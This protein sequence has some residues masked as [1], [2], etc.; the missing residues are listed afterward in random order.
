MARP[1]HQRKPTFFWQAALILLPVI[2]LAVMGWFSLRQDKILA[3]HDA[4][5]RAQVIA[6]D[7]LPKIWSEIISVPSRNFRESDQSLFEVD[8]VGNL[9]FPPPRP[10]IPTPKPFDLAE[11]NSEQARLWEIYCQAGART[12]NLETLSKS[13]K[14]FISSDPPENFAAAAQFDFGLRLE[15][16]KKFE[17]AVEAL[18]KVAN[19]YAD[20]LGETGLPLQPLAQLKLIELTARAPIAMAATNFISL[21][22]F[23]SNIV[24]HPTLLTPELWK[25][26]HQMEQQHLIAASPESTHWESIWGNHEAR[27]E[28]FSSFQGSLHSNPISLASHLLWFDWA[29]WAGWRQSGGES[30]AFYRP[31]HC[32]AIRLQ[33][34]VGK[35]ESNSWILFR[36]ESELGD[37]LTWFVEHKA[38]LPDFFGLG[39]EVAGRKIEERAPDLRVWRYDYYVSKGAGQVKKAYSDE[40]ATTILATATKAEE[41]VD[42]LKVNVYLTSPAALFRRQHARSFWFGSLIAVSTV[43]ALFGL[44]AA[45]RAFRR[46][47]QLSEMKSNFVSSVSHELRAPIASVRLMAE[48]LERGKIQ[49]PEKRN[50]Y[51]RFIVQE[52]RRLSAL[53]ENVLDFSRIEQGR[54]QYEFEPTDMVALV[55]QTVMLMEPYAVEKGVR[56]VLETSNTEHRTPNIESEIDGRAIQQALVNLIDNAIK[57][58][59]KGEVVTVGIEVSGAGRQVSSGPVSPAVSPDLTPGTSHIALFVEDHGPG[60]PR[61]EQQ[62]IFERFYRRGSELRRETQGVGIGLSIVK[63][64]VEAHGGRVRVQS[65]VGKGSRFTI[66]LPS[67]YSTTDGHR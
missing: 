27:R 23:L 65:E 10:A 52:C 2:V 37:K 28:L 61:E 24:F 13:F 55:K 58:S 66:E 26:V 43:A 34:E 8:R 46:Q 16:Q 25:R 47:L 30:F 36:N 48:N 15:R 1:I 62:K 59:P 29:R 67:K 18:H 35:A 12:Q 54:K 3:D 57:H 41:G 42:Q 50:E 53:I 11:L 4:K 49:E 7:L 51:F 40:Q 63:H 39:I 14:D 64:I 44:M 5:E 38:R 17:E 60:I 6:D 45:W 21:D 9:I 32:V 20:A 19:K 56:L 33:D 31:E 22:T